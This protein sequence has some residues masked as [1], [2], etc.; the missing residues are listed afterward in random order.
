MVNAFLSELG[1]RHVFSVAPAVASG[2]RSTTASTAT[3]S[4]S[5]ACSP[6]TSTRRRWGGS[7]RILAEGRER[8][9]D[10]GYRT[11]PGKPYLGRHAA[12]KADLAEAVRERAETRGLR[13]DVSTRAEDTFFGDDWYRFLASCRYTIGME[14]GASILDRDGT[15]R[16]AVDAYLAG[17]PDA[18]FE[19][20]EAAC[21]PGRDGELALFAISPRHLEACAT[22]TA[23]ILVEGEYAGILRPGEHYLELRR[24]LSNLDAVLDDG[25][26]R[27]AT[28]RTAS[29]PAATP[30]S[31]PR[32]ATR[33]AGSSR[34]SSASCPRSEGERRV[35]A[36]SLTRAPSTPP[37]GRWCRWRRTC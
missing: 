35:T 3:A 8:T 17:H 22:R 10:I 2:R 4:G 23:Q 13:V 33:T 29:P 32:A 9:I 30:R 12:L 24:D 34:T 14:G 31:S 28:R 18:S 36:G 6:D 26:G 7:T 25:R 37:P 15:V 20:L 21:F 11:V 19:E 16:Q 27:R 1:V 5:R